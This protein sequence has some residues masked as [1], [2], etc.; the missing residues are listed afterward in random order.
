MTN[1]CEAAENYIRAVNALDRETQELSHATGI[2][3]F[4]QAD[5]V[6]EARQELKSKEIEL[7]AA[8]RST[9]L[10]HKD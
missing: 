2:R 9:R 6:N 4:V 1:L 3:A 10:I 8:I 5:A 7:Q